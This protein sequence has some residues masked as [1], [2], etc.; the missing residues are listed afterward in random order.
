MHGDLNDI[1]FSDHVGVEHLREGI[2]TVQVQEVNTFKM[3]LFCMIMHLYAA[4]ISALA[5][6]F[7]VFYYPFN[8][9]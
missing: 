4:I 5:C 8:K 1:L 6:F 9:D 3:S 2:C 7:L